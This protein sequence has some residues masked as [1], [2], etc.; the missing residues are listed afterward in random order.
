MAGR[1]RLRIETLDWS[2][3]DCKIDVDKEIDEDAARHVLAGLFNAS[4]WKEH[5][6]SLARQHEE[7]LAQSSGDGHQS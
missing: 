3:E 4:I 1:Y 7:R 2:S 6:R 5:L